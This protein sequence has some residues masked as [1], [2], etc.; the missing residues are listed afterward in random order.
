[1][2]NSILWN[3]YTNTKIYLK[4]LKHNIIHFHKWVEYGDFE[5]FPL[6]F[7]LYKLKL[8]TDHSLM[9]HNLQETPHTLLLQVYGAF[10][11]INV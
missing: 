4:Y 6:P 3:D 7:K 11:A 9:Y 5:I 2:Q 1:M 10:L 8:I